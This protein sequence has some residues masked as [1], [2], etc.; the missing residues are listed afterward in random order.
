VP[1]CVDDYLGGVRYPLDLLT[2]LMRSTEGIAEVAASLTA[3]G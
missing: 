3:S 1:R 2:H